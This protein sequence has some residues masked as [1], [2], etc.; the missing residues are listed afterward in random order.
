MAKP[1]KEIVK[2]GRQSLQLQTDRGKEFTVRSFS[3]L[4]FISFRRTVMPGPS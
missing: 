4:G 2:E 1:F 3:V